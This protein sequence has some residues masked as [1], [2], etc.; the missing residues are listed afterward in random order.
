MSFE[1]ADFFSGE[2]SNC[3]KLCDTHDIMGDNVV[4]PCG[5]MLDSSLDFD[6]MEEI[7]SDGCWL[8]TAADGSDFLLRS[9]SAASNPLLDSSFS[10][11]ALEHNG[12]VS[13]EQQSK[14]L[15]MIGDYLE[16]AQVNT[17]TNNNDNRSVGKGKDI[18]E[19]SGTGNNM[20]DNS[21]V[22]RRL[23]IGPMV[24]PSPE[25]SVLER[26]IKALVYIRDFNRDKDMLLQLWVPVNREGGRILSTRDLP[27]SLES[28][29]P[30]LAKY[31][32]I[33]AKYLFP[34]EEYSRGLV[35]GLPGRVFREKVPEWTPDV[36]FFRSDEYPR[37]D[38]AQEYDVR[39]SLAIPV[40]E[41][42]SSICLGVIEVVMT[43]QKIKYF[44]ELESVCNALQVFLLAFLSLILFGHHFWDGQVHEYTQ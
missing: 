28:S 37:V 15:L 6:Y 30:N 16:E 8:E 1:F 20:S 38:H 27:F 19:V 36:R 25:C 3:W 17:N 24:N 10:W 18:I 11:P 29:S 35:P 32:E 31:R 34:A 26:L 44:P 21:E 43:A 12:H 14:S 39:G 41:K 33:S 4:S 9:P 40:F 5:A 42:C 13:L 22:V 2:A 23:W 7:F